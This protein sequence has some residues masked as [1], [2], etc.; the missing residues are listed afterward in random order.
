MPRQEV[1]ARFLI[2]KFW[3]FRKEV[4]ELCFVPPSDEH[5]VVPGG[6]R[7][8]VRSE[9]HRHLFHGKYLLPFYVFT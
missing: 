3:S 5:I 4:L 7:V 9:E 2:D 6:T 8:P 1:N